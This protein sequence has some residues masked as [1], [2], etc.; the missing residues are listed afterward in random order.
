[1]LVLTLFIILILTYSK[2]NLS[3]A[4]EEDELCMI[5][6]NEIGT[7]TNFYSCQEAIQLIREGI[8]PVLCGF[9]RFTPIVCCK[10]KRGV[11]E[12]TTTISKEAEI[13]GCSAYNILDS[14]ING[15]SLEFPHMAI[16]GYGVEENIKWRCSGALID[17][18][19]VLTSATCANTEFGQIK[20]VNLG[21]PQSSRKEFETSVQT[22]GVKGIYF[23]PKRSIYSYYHDI[24]LIELDGNVDLKGAVKPACLQTTKSLPALHPIV[25]NWRIFNYRSKWFEKSELSYVPFETCKDRHKPQ[26]YLEGGVRY[27]WQICA[28][29]KNVDTDTFNTT[30][31]LNNGEYGMC[32]EILSCPVHKKLLSDR[33]KLVTCG[34]LRKTPIICCPNPEEKLKYIVQKCDEYRNLTHSRLLNTTTGLK[35]NGSINYEDI[36][37]GVS[38]DR[39]EF[40]HMALLGYGNEDSIRW[41]CGGSLISEKFVLTAAHC[42]RSRITGYV[43]YVAL[44]VYAVDTMNSNTNVQK[45]GVKKIYLPSEYETKFHYHDIALLEL[46]STVQLHLGV[47]PACLYA[48]EKLPNETFTVIGWGAT[49]SGGD[50][51]NILQEA[52]LVEVNYN[53]C[54]ISYSPS[55]KLPYGLNETHQMC[56]EGKD[57]SWADTCQG[58]SGG[59]LQL[60][61]PDMLVYQVVGITSFGKKCTLVP[62]VYTKVSNY[63]PWIEN[64]VWPEVT[65]VNNTR[66]RR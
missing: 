65:Q 54:K 22:F 58:D 56:A 37:G 4:L 49:M 41:I 61:L 43:K 57:E 31:R 63:I 52:E 32:M 42:T 8:K 3:H 6:N 60:K 15:N 24:A 28:V 21:E 46:N 1:M 62:G 11:I 20:Y 47:R 7:C 44:G 53:R 13:R 66:R 36:A 59:P 14:S 35:P 16:L 40:P 9:D 19:Y 17:E 23:H 48:N 29:G 39:F 2:N 50:T 30:C 55:V 45:F 10:R 34:Y 33:S 5:N 64:I 25:A 26:A 51:A 38:S 27:N 18:K 12:E